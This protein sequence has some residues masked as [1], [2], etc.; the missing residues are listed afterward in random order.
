MHH[1]TIATTT[2]NLIESLLSDTNVEKIISIFSYKYGSYFMMHHKANDA[3]A[4]TNELPKVYNNIFK[5][6]GNIV[7]P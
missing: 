6:I 7:R 2:M 5:L 3:D 4:I 1:T